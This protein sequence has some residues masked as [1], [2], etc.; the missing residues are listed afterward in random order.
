MGG[1]RAAS[2]AADAASC[3]QDR[4]A[5]KKEVVH[6]D[7][8]GLGLVDSFQRHSIQRARMPLPINYRRQSTFNSPAAR[9]AQHSLDSLAKGRVT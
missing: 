7:V 2:H 4:L 6:V 3:H 5:S 9:N 1:L 8:G